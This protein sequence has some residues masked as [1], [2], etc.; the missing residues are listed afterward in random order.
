MH[1]FSDTP[2]FSHSLLITKITQVLTKIAGIRDST[3]WLKSWIIYLMYHLIANHLFLLYLCHFMQK[4]E[5]QN[6]HFYF[7]LTTACFPRNAIPILMIE[8]TPAPR[9]SVSYFFSSI[10]RSALSAKTVKSTC[11]SLVCLNSRQKPESQVLFSQSN[12]LY[13]TS[14]LFFHP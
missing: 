6:T 13:D 2:L 1:F 14:L 7:R 4:L 8:L 10:Y 3:G 11:S 9:S 12:I 5:L